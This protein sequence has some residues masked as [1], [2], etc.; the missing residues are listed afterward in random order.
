L[1]RDSDTSIIYGL[2][3]NDELQ[4][5]FDQAQLDGLVIS[6]A[7]DSR[8]DGVA[9]ADELVL[10]N[11]LLPARLLA[12][13]SKSGVKRVV[14]IGTA[15]QESTAGGYAPWN[16][17]A[18][19]K[20][21]ASDI[22]HH[23]ASRDL[24]ISELHLFETY[25]DGDTRAKVYNLMLD[26]AVLHQP[27]VLS[28]GKQ[29]LHLVHIQDVCT[30][31]LMELERSASSAFQCFRIDSQKA[32]TVKDLATAVRS[33]APGFQAELGGR[34]YRPNEILDPQSRHARPPRWAP[35]VNLDEGLRACLAW[36]VAHVDVGDQMASGS[37][38]CG[39]EPTGTW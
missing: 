15:W 12:A 6:G 14:L 38:S 30:A 10:G 22:A 7:A 1:V 35:A 28:P 3:T 34:T 21:A 23:F 11:V 24:A 37:P 26:A 9:D 4:R 2:S 29:R 19:T 5:Q 27:I 17:Y 18:A 13:A 16:L 32:I 25:G 20:Q 39:A 33:I 8:Q 36:K 31:I